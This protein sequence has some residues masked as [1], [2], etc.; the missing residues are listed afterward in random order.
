MWIKRIELTNWR[1]YHRA[2]IEIP[3]GD[4][5]SN[6]VVIGAKNGFGKTSLLEAVTLC[7]FGM[8]GL[9][10]LVRT[11]RTATN[12]SAVYNKFLCGAFHRLADLSSPKASVLLVFEADDSTEISVER[13][14]HF[15]ANRE[16]RGQEDL[17]I[18]ENGEDLPIPVSAA[19]LPADRLT[20]LAAHIAQRFLPWTLSPFFLFDSLRVQRMARRDMKEQVRD[21]IEATLGVPIVNSLVKDLHDYA[22]QRRNRGMAGRASDAKLE[23][24]RL[25][26]ERGEAASKEATAEL[27]D[28]TAQLERAGAEENE[29]VRKFENMD[30]DSVAGLGELRLK[31]GG[32]KRS[33]DSQLDTLAKSIVGDFAMSLAGTDMLSETATRL[34]AET[35]RVV[36]ERDKK[37]G[38]R[39]L[40]QIRSE[41]GADG[42]PILAAEPRASR[43]TTR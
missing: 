32:L 16:F 27:Q 43:A 33:R 4:S 21:G 3:R 17:F 36:W 12:E 5:R 34:R 9:G 31:S 15:G 20:F 14:W 6:V 38:R 28:L 22:T 24:L 23:S 18:R 35:A 8:R 29:M 39:E 2:V 13:V 7:L 19:D 11:E 25:N 40:R 30:G 10:N 26:I 41:L 42:C 1:V 37:R